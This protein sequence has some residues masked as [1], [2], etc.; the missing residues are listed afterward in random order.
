MLTNTITTKP[1][2]GLPKKEKSQPTDL[3]GT[4]E[5]KKSS[6][7]IGN[8]FE[9]AILDTCKEYLRLELAYIQKNATPTVWIPPRD[10]KQGF[11][12][13][14]KKTGFDFVGCY[15]H[16]DTTLV[17]VAKDDETRFNPTLWLPI[18]IEAK[19]TKEN[20]INCYQE[21]GGIT[22]YQVMQM[23]W[24]EVHGLEAYFIW[25]ARSSNLIFKITPQ[26]LVNM[27]MNKKSLTIADCAENHVPRIVTVRSGSG[28]F[29]DFLN[30]LDN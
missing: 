5:K 17:N 23:Q 22:A 26:Q 15:K 9:K 11:L 6:A 4:P 25:Q 8:T 28:I 14:S 27:T 1:R 20:S 7:S 2:A 24:L 29:L 3:F 30:L 13:H 18:F 19:T 21:S 12:M 16:L 10:G